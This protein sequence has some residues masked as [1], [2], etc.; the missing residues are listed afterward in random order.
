MAKFELGT[1]R[2]LMISGPCSAESEGQ[3]LSTCEALAAEGCVD[4]LRAGI[5]KP[6]TRPNTFEGRGVE[7][8]PWLAEAKRRTG[9]PVAIEVASAKHVEAALS[10]GVDILWV[11]ARTTVN[12]FLVQEVAE[13]VAGSDVTVLIKNPMN[14]DIE[15]WSGAVERFEKAGIPRK[16]IGLIHRGFSVSGHSRYR[17]NPMW[18]L[19]FEMQN[20]HPDLPM[21]CDPSH[22][23]GDSCYVAE[24]A[25]TAANLNFD[26]LIVE[27]HCSPSEALS[28]AKQQLT[29]SALGELVRNLSWRAER[30]DDEAYLHELERCRNEID[31][32]DSEVFELLGR[33]MDIADHIG[34]IKREN[35][36]VI[37]QSERWYSIVERLLSRNDEL[38][39]SRTFIRSI[40][41]AIHV[42]SI[43]HQNRIMNEKN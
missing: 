1:K 9:L 26:G 16:N 42:E 39:L 15:L 28:D 37:L 36:V 31:M 22:I 25:Q 14:P 3:L 38:H 8:L 34:R 19:A 40:L 10:F 20:R 12:P 35:D 43:E 33:R 5:W 6:R 27:S 7:A 11:G 41:E 2:P 4:V 18:Y 29:P 13:A 23:C 17:N 24:V 32:I 30:S 21:L